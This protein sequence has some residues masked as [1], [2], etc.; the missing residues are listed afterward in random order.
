MFSNLLL[1]TRS[2]FLCHEKT[3]SPLNPCQHL[4]VAFSGSH[5]GR[6][7]AS[8]L[9]V[10]VVFLRSLGWHCSSGSILLEFT[11]TAEM[12]ALS[13]GET[14]FQLCSFL[15]HPTTLFSQDTQA[16]NEESFVF[17][18]FFFSSFFFSFPF[19]SFP[20]IPS[21]FLSSLRLKLSR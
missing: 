13:F 17:F 15:Y 3:L 14:G 7:S 20:F 1:K 12:L 2:C 16:M 19:F 6:G 8:F 4:Q 11:A 21:S 10:S 9:Q 18:L 5:Q